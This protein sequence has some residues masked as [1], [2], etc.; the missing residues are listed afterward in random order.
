MT[1]ILITGSSDGIGQIVARNLI[2]QGHQVTLHA[3]NAPRAAQ[4][5]AAL[6]G[7]E[8]V[9]IADL[10]SISGEHEDG[11][12]LCFWVDEESYRVADLAGYAWATGDREWQILCCATSEKSA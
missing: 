2:A 3:R 6:P 11:R 9:L 5:L 12:C 10:S 4:A 7:A 8:G 1:R